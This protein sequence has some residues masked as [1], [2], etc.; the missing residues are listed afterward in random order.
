LPTS[1]NL[2]NAGASHAALV[3]VASTQV[4]SLQRVTAGNPA[5]SYLVRKLEGAPNIVGLQMPRNAPPL[6]ATTIAVVREWIS[7]GA[8]Q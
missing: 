3:G 7:N 4:P 8:L 2:T 1:I 6:D 5:D